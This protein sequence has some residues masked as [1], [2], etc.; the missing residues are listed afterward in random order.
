MFGIEDFSKP[1]VDF[2]NFDVSQLS[3]ALI[4]GGAIVLIGMATVFAVLCLLWLFLVIFKVVFH[5][6][7]GKSP[8][9]AKAVESAVQPDR[10]PDLRPAENGE[11]V[12]VLA[13]A[14]AMA[15]SENSGMKF[16]VVS[17]KR[18]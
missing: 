6:L 9:K 2:S 13:A 8:K 4:F 16:R 18:V 3:D 15:E 17:F 10:S 5:D 12:A 14:V 11:I 1:I 7:P